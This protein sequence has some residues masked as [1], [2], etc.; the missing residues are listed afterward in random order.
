MFSRLATSFA[1]ESARDQ[2]AESIAPARRGQSSW[3]RE[4]T[5]WRKKTQSWHDRESGT[6]EVMDAHAVGAWLRGIG[7]ESAARAAEREAIGGCE[8]LA[9]LD[10]D[11]GLE[12][13]LG[14]SK[15]VQR[16]KIR[17]G[18][19]S[20]LL[21]AENPS[22][23]LSKSHAFK[24]RRRHGDDAHEP[25]GAAAESSVDP[26]STQSTMFEKVKVHDEFEGRTSVF[27][28]PP[29]QSLGC[30]I[31]SAVV[32]ADPSSARGGC[33]HSFCR[34]CLKTWLRRK[35]QCPKCRQRVPAQPTTEEQVVRNTDLC[36]I[37]AEQKVHCPAGVKRSGDGQRWCVDPSGCSAQLELKDVEEHLA[38]CEHHVV[39]CSGAPHGCSWKSKRREVGEH[40]AQCV[41][42][43]LGGRV[44]D[45]EDAL[46]YSST[47]VRMLT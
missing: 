42:V 41:Y 15:P 7:L 1:A 43:H 27:V 13:G 9:L 32:M 26:I 19:R 47:A 18:V 28:R 4:G 16:A 39:A 2:P 6:M 36:G 11:G 37:A 45:L 30:I 44:A 29:P 8:L 10:E 3:A 31:C 21:R 24:R 46:G 25:A 12:D 35:A 38:S 14:V 23:P 22:E 5:P 20:R 40:Q 17:G 33:T 34:E